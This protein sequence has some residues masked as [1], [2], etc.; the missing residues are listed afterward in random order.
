MVSLVLNAAGNVLFLLDDVSSVV[1]AYQ[2]DWGDET[3]SFGDAP[4]LGDKI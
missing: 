1:G 4:F 3:I 2:I